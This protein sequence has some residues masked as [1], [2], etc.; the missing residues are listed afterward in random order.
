MDKIG[1]SIAAAAVYLAALCLRG[2]FGYLKNNKIAIENIKFDIRKFFGGAVRPALL[3]LGIGALAA[4]IMAFL[5]IVSAS[6]LTVVGIDQVTVEHLLLGLFVADIGAI[7]YAMSEALMAFGLS[8]KQIEQI[9]ATVADR[10]SDEKTGVEVKDNDGELEAIAVNIKQDD[11]NGETA[12]EPQMGAMW[13]YYKVDV[14]TP[15]AFVNA[16]NGKG[17]NE[18]FGFQCVAGFKEFTFSLCGKVVATLTGGASGYAKQVGQICALGF[19]H[20]TDRKLQDGDWVIFGGG[21]YG[22]VAM[23]YKGQFFGQN[24]NAANGSRGNAFNLANIGLNNYLCHYRPNIYA[25]APAPTPKPDPTPTPT[26]SPAPADEV[27]YV[28]QKG[29]TFGEVILKLGLATSH[30]LWGEDGDVEFYTKQLNAAGIFGNIPVGT[31]IKL[32]RRK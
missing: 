27:S 23:F 1:L 31:T 20:H 4:L 7:G 28:Y 13:P 2:I 5:K 24:Q 29:D 12:D 16:V 9:R 19:T 8:E 6:G 17:F 32:T 18:G 10:E 30:G 3:T 26:P 11:A 15:S 21:K 25:K 14:S 22:H